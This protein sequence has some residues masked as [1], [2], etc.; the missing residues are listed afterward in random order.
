MSASVT[1]DAA[2]QV[3]ITEV[4]TN[5]VEVQAPAAPAVVQV[6]VEGPQGPPGPQGP[7]GADGVTTL[8]AL[9]DVNVSGKVNQSVLYWDQASGK[10]RGDDINTVVTIT[11]GG[12]F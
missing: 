9:N 7:A 2:P 12:N 11:D 3:I 4:A 8:A 1:G 10:W 6:A 5:V